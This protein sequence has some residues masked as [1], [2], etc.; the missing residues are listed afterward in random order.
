[1]LNDGF[2]VPRSGQAKVASQQ[3]DGPRTKLGYDTYVSEIDKTFHW[4][5]RSNRS[6]SVV[7]HDSVVLD[8]SIMHIEFIVDYISQPTLLLMILKTLVLI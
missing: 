3:T 2:Q 6:R 5:S 1:M 8:S 4:L 7:V